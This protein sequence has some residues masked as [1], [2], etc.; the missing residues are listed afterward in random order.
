MTS[1]QA[2]PFRPP[3]VAGCRSTIDGVEYGA[4][5]YQDGTVRL[6]QAGTEL[7]S[8]RFQ[9]T[10]TKTVSSIG[11]PVVSFVSKI[12]DVPYFV[13]FSAD[14]IAQLEG[15]LTFFAFRAGL[16]SGKAVTP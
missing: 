4:D 1:A 14:V 12:V 16:F 9:A 11:T 13:E 5:L 3:F 7:G 10:R 2:W 6:I 15:D 8:G